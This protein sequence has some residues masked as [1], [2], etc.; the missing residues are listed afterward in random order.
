MR[1][2]PISLRSRAIC[3]TLVELLDPPRRV[4]HGTNGWAGTTAG[5]TVGAGDRSRAR[6]E[7][8]P[9]LVAELGDR[10]KAR[11]PED[12]LAG[13]G[14]EG[15]ES[16]LYSWWVDESGAA[17]LSGGLGHRSSPGL[18]Y[19]GLAG[20]TR[21]PSG[22][23]STN[24]LWSRIAG[25]HLGGR[26]EFS[27]FRRTLGSILA[28]AEGLAAINEDALTAWMR[29]HLVVRTAVH[30]DPDVLGETRSGRAQRARPA[31][32]PP[33]NARHAGPHSPH[34]TAQVV[35]PNLTTCPARPRLYRR[36]PSLGPTS[37]GTQRRHAPDDGQRTQ[38]RSRGSNSKPT[39]YRLQGDTS[40]LTPRS[41]Q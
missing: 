16:G 17:D 19:A 9:L 27:T 40:L 13:R 33:R 26:H 6:P 31:A 41:H 38:R 14:T 1:P 21:W 18:V 25:M 2:R 32:Q 10:S 22:K 11:S 3:A 37:V 39:T 15:Q 7:A 35:R 4:A 29:R 8:A 36:S 5:R 30:P 24:T 12:L 20:A 23:R 34:R 28:A